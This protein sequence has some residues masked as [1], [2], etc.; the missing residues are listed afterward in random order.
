MELSK[1]ANL[2]TDI[3]RYGSVFRFPGGWPYEPMVDF[4]L[5]YSPGGE[6]ESALIVATG[7]K[8]GLIAILLPPESGCDEAGGSGISKRWVIDN[9]NKWIWP[10]CSV[11]DVYV[12]DRYDAPEKF[13]SS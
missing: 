6:R 3:V 4:L 1:L 7:H 2:D 8:A 11:D 9:W 13:L 10:D 5:A 12:I